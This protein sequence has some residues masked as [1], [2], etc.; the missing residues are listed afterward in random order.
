MSPNMLGSDL[1]DKAVNE[2]RYLNGTPSLG[3]QYSK[4]SGLD[5][6]GYRDYDYAECNMDSKSTSN[7]CQLLEGK[8]IC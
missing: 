8:L 2:S 6:K 7:A 1:N 5:L 4:R 3:I